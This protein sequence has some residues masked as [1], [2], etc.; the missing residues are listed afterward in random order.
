MLLLLLN[1]EYDP[2]LEVL[3]LLMLLVKTVASDSTSVL[4]KDATEDDVAAEVGVGARTTKVEADVLLVVLGVVVKEEDC[5]A[6]LVDVVNVDRRGGRG[7]DKTG[8]AKEEVVLEETD[9]HH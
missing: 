3:L 6:L 2:E 8:D 7:L 1:K 9:K 4:V 5:S